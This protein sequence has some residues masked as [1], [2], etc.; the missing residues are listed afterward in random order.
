MLLTLTATVSAS[1][2][3]SA[4]SAD[5]AMQ[6]LVEGNERFASGNATHPHQSSLRLAEVTSG[7]HPFAIVVG[8]SDSRVP[9]EI[10]FD[11]GIGDLFIIRTA[12][13]VLD[14]AAVASIEYAVEHLG[15]PLVAVLG[16]DSCGAVTAVVAGGDA[17]GHLGSLV[18]AIQPAVDEARAEVGEDQILN[19]SI[20]NNIFN[21]VQQIE[22]SEPV[23]AEYV[24]DGRLQVVGARYHLETGAVDFYE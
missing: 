11:Q 9:P 14:D 1:D 2:E 5:Q 18:E 10:I 12:G 8:C 21:I 24:A 22:S 15:V 19:Q 6:M 16:H 13:Q 4:V 23:L 17:P 3:A 7:Q 20:D